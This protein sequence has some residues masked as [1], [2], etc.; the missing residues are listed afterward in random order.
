MTAVMTKDIREKC[1]AKKKG[2]EMQIQ[3]V[4]GRKKAYLDLLLL[5]DPS[6]DMIDRYL[7]RSDMYVGIVGGRVVCEAVVMKTGEA[8]CELKNLATLQGEQGKGYASR[9]VRFL[10]SRYQEQFT[11]MTVGTSE[12]GVAFY[13]RLGFAE[14]GMRAG[15][16]TNY[17]PPVYENGRIC[18]DMILLEKSL[19]RRRG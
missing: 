5:A 13:R 6:E 8:E 9:L 7:E 19:S 12:G 4:E 17:D 14:S 11:A 2:R 15:F 18:Q 16:F 1:A 10:F 3:K